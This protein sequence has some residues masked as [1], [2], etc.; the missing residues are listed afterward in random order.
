[1]LEKENRAHLNTIANM[2]AMPKTMSNTSL[3]QQKDAEITR[4]NEHA[5]FQETVV[6]NLSREIRQKTSE[7][8]R[9]NTAPSNDAHRQAQND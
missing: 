6:N 9:V 4:L 8:N 2:S 5:K 7:L 3:I 1:V